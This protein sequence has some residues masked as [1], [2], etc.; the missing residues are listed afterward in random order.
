VQAEL[1]KL[2]ADVTAR[3]EEVRA[4]LGQLPPDAAS[5][6]LDARLEVLA[7][8]LVEFE[9]RT[10]QALVEAAHAG[11]VVEELEEAVPP[12]ESV[13]PAP[14]LFAALAGVLGAGLVL[15]C[16]SLWFLAVGPEEADLLPI[17]AWFFGLLA[18]DP[19]VPAG[20]TS[21]CVLSLLAILAWLA[22][23]LQFQYWSFVLA[24]ALPAMLMAYGFLRSFHEGSMP[25]RMRWL[26]H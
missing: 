24:A 17:T 4:E 20:V 12:T 19:Q 1:E 10:D 25:E 14:G 5:P 2:R 21:R 7:S 6:D 3:I 26:F 11:S 15:G 22:F 16:G 13:A 23:G 9:S 8:Q 18:R